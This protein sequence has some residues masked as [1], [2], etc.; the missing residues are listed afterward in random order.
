MTATPEPRADSAGVPFAG[1]EFRPNPA[2]DDDG[3]ADPRLTGIVARFRSGAATL[4]D[5]IAVLHDTRVLA[6]LVAERGADGTGPHGQLVDKTQELALVTVAAPDGRAALPVFSSVDALRAWNADARPIPVA[7][8]RVA[9]AAAGE[10]TQLLVLDAGGPGELAVRRPAFRALA[11]GE[12]WTPAWRDDDVL[13]ALRRATSGEDVVRDARLADGD[14]DARLAGPE[15][16]VELA[17]AP[18]LDR[19]GLDALVRRVTDAWAREEVVAERVDSI[20]I[21]L[22][23]AG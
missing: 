14:P 18:G 17:V 6:P 2:A 23:R 15:V 22:T 16:V 3:A 10:G 7:A 9:L 21:R 13:A 8:S 20:A 12:A 11:L 1:R 5:V 4:P 19:A